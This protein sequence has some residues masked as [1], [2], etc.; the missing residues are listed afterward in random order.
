MN[1]QIGQKGKYKMIK[2]YEIYYK[3][4]NFFTG[5]KCNNCGEKMI[6]SGYYAKKRCS[7]HCIGY[8]ALLF[9]LLFFITTKNIFAANLVQ[10]PDFNASPINTNWTQDG[11]NV[12]FSD[13]TEDPGC[14]EGDPVGSSGTNSI[15]INS[16]SG[17][18]D[19][20]YQAVSVTASTDYILGFSTY[21]CSR[22][23]N[24]AFV[25]VNT[26]SGGGGE[27]AA[28]EITDP[29]G[30]EG[31]W[32]DR[33]V[34][35]NSGSNTTVYIRVKNNGGAVVAGVDNFLMDVYATPTPTPTITPTM[36]PT[37][38]PTPTSTMDS[39]YLN[40]MGDTVALM[41]FNFGFILFS[42]GVLIMLTIF[43]K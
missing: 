27:L 16:G 25:L 43:K 13:Y 34:T 36:A 9:L 33:V 18:N 30:G 35:F 20:V 14:V 26:S 10:N 3:F 40:A 1:L 17:N 21:L 11:T 22:S 32:Y 23:G 28:Q 24:S 42:L 41:N 37:P 5:E 19:Y 2:I 12:F 38:T 4:I 8:S 15:T 29:S 6:E 31:V 39:A 7:Y